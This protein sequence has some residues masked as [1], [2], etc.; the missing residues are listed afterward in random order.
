MGPLSTE[1][2]IVTA[3]GRTSGIFNPN[4]NFVLSDT[5][6]IAV[7]FVKRWR[8]TMRFNITFGNPKFAGM[9]KG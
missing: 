2:Q 1:L 3:F 7:A 4:R 6:A 9:S 5:Q 8:R